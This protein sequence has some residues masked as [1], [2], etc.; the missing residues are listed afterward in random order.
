[1]K[2]SYI[3]DDLKSGKTYNAKAKKTRFALPF[4]DYDEFKL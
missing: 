4:A 3:H 1:M 2:K